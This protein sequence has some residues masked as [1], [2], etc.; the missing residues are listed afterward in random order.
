MPPSR[1]PSTL[2]ADKSRATAQPFGWVA[3][4]AVA[5]PAQ[6]QDPGM[7]GAAVRANALAG[8]VRAATAAG[9]PTRPAPD[10][11][12]PAPSSARSTAAP[13]AARP[14]TAPAT[15]PATARERQDGVWVTSIAVTFVLL[16]MIAAGASVTGNMRTGRS[17]SAL[18]STLARVHDEQQ[19][20]RIIN[21]R[22]ATWSELARRGVALSPKQRVVASNAS[23]SHWF[24]SVRDTTTG[25]ICSRTG[26]LFDESADDRP[27][28]CY[29]DDDLSGP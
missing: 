20:F 1:R 6:R 7:N 4:P 17:Q 8:A 2:A 12:S 3:A 27:P 29:A 16:M 15:Q 5:K 22:F 21:Q 28:N 26:E 23:A 14:A 13:V 9:A 19:S 10:R 24:L 18:N 25:I 11:L